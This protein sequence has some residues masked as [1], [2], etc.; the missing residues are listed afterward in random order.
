MITITDSQAREIALK[1]QN[2]QVKY[3]GYTI[4]AAIDTASSAGETTAIARVK[5]ELSD[6]SI[7]NLGQYGIRIT[8]TKK[9]SGL[10][11]YTFSIADADADGE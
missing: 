10:I 3:D 5:N 4:S 8:N 9:E 2:N 6:E 11:Q 1:A 7:E